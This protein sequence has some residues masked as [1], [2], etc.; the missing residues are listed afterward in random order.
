MAPLLIS[1]ALIGLVTAE[2]HFNTHFGNLFHHVNGSHC[3]ADIVNMS[4]VSGPAECE[5]RCLKASVCRIWV[6]QPSTGACWLGSNGDYLLLPSKDRI[7]GTLS[8]EPLMHSF[9]IIDLVNELHPGGLGILLG[10]GKGEWAEKILTQWN[11]GIYLVDPYIHIWNKENDLDDRTHQIIYENLRTKFHQ[12]FDNRFVFVRDFSYSLAP[13]WT[14][15]SMPNPSF[16]FIDKNANVE[17]LHTDI[18]LWWPILAEGGIMAGIE[19]FGP[20]EQVQSAID[21]YF[22]SIFVKVHFTTFNSTWF[23]IKPI[24]AENECATVTKTN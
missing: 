9:D 6:T 1:V 15:K 21:T 16:I 23:V 20:N 11:G 17:A 24:K 5:E 14:A 13:I 7:A 8:N 18:E 12:Q 10:V 3:C 4:P 22:T 19:Y 2:I